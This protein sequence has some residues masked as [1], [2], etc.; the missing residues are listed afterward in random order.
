MI[1]PRIRSKTETEPRT[2]TQTQALV[3]NHFH[4][5][6]V[7]C[8][9]KPKKKRHFYSI[10]PHLDCLLDCLLPGADDAHQQTGADRFPES[11]AFRV[12]KRSLQGSGRGPSFGVTGLGLAVAASPV[13]GEAGQSTRCGPLA[14]ALAPTVEM[15]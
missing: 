3:A 13:A 4:R 8:E 12:L 10:H 15:L 14:S 1:S 7:C 9:K 11:L 2:Q 6:H 5:M